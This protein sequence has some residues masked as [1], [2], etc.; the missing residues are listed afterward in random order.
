MNSREKWFRPLV[1]LFYII[2]FYFFTQNHHEIP[3]FILTFI[4]CAWL[5]ATAIDSIKQIYHH[6]YTLAKGHNG[7][8]DIDEFTSLEKLVAYLIPAFIVTGIF[9]GTMFFITFIRT[10][11]LSVHL[12]LGMVSIPVVILLEWFGFLNRRNPD[13]KRRKNDV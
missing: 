9:A 2:L 10:G 6:R 7:V 3:L 12:F 4:G 11:D 1:T 13:K 8:R 5:S